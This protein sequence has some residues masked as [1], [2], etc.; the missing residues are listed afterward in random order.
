MPGRTPGQE[1]QGRRR[2]AHSCPVCRGQPLL[3]GT[4]LTL[5]R[6]PSSARAGCEYGSHKFELSP[7]SWPCCSMGLPASMVQA[8][9]GQPLHRAAGMQVDSCRRAQLL[10]LARCACTGSCHTYMRSQEGAQDAAAFGAAWRA[11]QPNLPQ[12]AAQAPAL[13]KRHGGARVCLAV[14]G[15]EEALLTDRDQAAGQRF[16]EGRHVSDPALHSAS[17]GER[18][19]CAEALSSKLVNFACSSRRGWQGS[20]YASGA[21]C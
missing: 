3:L 4:G 2:G 5:R 9:D 21:V 1:Q 13:I 11:G 16:D 15:L 14:G 8:S 17:T 10:Y 6:W 7:S 20:S 12:L 18:R 19:C